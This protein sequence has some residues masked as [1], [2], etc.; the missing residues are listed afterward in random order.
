MRAAH[1]D[2]GI[3]GLGPVGALA[4]NLLAS[5]GLSVFAADPTLMPY[6][7][8]RAKGLDH[9]S[10]RL[11]QTLGLAEPLTP[12]LGDYR[13]AEYRAADGQVLRRILPLPPPHPL[14]WP[15]YVT[16]S[17][18]GLERLLRGCFNRWPNL[19]VALGH[20]STGVT[21]EEGCVQITIENAETRG[22]RKISCGYVLA[23]DGASS[24]TREALGMKLEDLGFDEPWLV[25]D[26]RAGAGAVL[27]DATVQY[28]DPARPCTFIHG[29]G[30]VRRWEL[31]LLPGEDPTEMVTD[32]KIWELLASWLSPGQ[33][34]IW[35]AATYRFHALVA[36]DWRCG[37]VFLLGDAAHQT[38][39]FMAQ[40]LNQGFR[41]VANL[42]WKLADVISG[43][44]QPSLLQ[45]YDRE[46]RPN[47]R[48]VVELTKKLGQII[49]ERDPHRVAVR[50][51]RMLQEMR[52]GTGEMVRQNLLPP[53]TTG[54]LLRDLSGALTPGAGL[55]FPQPWI[56][57]GEKRR[58]MDDELN[59]H[60]LMV[61]TT[62]DFA[63][64]EI[65]R[66]L[67][68]ELGVTFVRLDGRDDR[69]EVRGLIEDGRI[70]EW[71]Q[72]HAP[73]C[74]VLVRPDHIV[75]GSRHGPGAE[76]ILLESLNHASR[77]T[78]S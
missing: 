10:L 22:T 69:G 17:Q 5:K 20:R 51:D 43:R 76:R 19:E 4:A 2:I 45:S 42:C 12:Y 49:C 14:A 74:A 27:P 25:V 59:A 67:A 13:A 21:N 16:F 31:M 63:P 47:A 46:R 65:E 39:P 6:D 73:N 72:I 44:A 66:R 77:A 50:N 60:F 35:R 40:G 15:P 3:I 52:D 53:L 61:V 30:N 54:F 36:E 68:F 23:C 11:L 70:A 75:F 1:Y 57:T 41:D 8:P 71:Q 33:G 18:P 24:P 38:P 28:C 56:G 78:E 26:I 58:R 7:K 37:R 32:E 9:E 62:P 34:Q 48:A 55:L 64:D 29:P